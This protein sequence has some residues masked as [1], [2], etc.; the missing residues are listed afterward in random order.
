M[1]KTGG[2]W[3]LTEGGPWIGAFLEAH[4]EPGSTIRSD[5]LNHYPPVLAM[6]GYAHDRRVQGNPAKTGQVVPFAHRRSPT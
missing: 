3:L 5:G 1:T 4:V 6:L 2:I